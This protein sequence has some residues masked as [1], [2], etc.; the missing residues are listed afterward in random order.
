MRE[1][2]VAP[3]LQGNAQAQ[4]NLG[5]ILYKR[6]SAR[7]AAAAAAESTTHESTRSADSGEITTDEPDKEGSKGEDAEVIQAFELW[8]A[9][10]EREHPDALFN[11]GAMLQVCAVGDTRTLPLPF[12]WR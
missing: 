2:L 6:G 12:T 10:A 7:A 4:F 8:R 9:A 11:V 3:F 1:I 5:T